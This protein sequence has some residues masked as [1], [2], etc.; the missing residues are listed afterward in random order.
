MSKDMG[1]TAEGLKA[2]RDRFDQT[3]PEDAD[4]RKLLVCAP[5]RSEIAGNHTDHEGGQV[6]ACAVD[7][8]VTGIF[9]TREDD[10]AHVQSAGYDPVTLDLS[11]LDPQPEEEN[12]TAALVRGLV[13]GF[14][15]AGYGKAGSLGFDCV[16]QSQ[17]PA[18]S[19][20]SSSA[21]FELQ[22]AQALNALWA[23]G[24]LDAITLAQ[25][26]QAA[27][28]DF[29]GKPCG[30]MDQ[31]SVSVGGLAHMNFHEAEARVQKLDADFGQ[32]GYALVLTAVGADHAANTDDYAAVPSEMQAVA[33][34]LGASRLSDVTEE[35]LFDHVVELRQKLGDRPVLRALHY[36]REERFVGERAKALNE[37]D[38]RRFLVLTRASGASSAMYLQNVSVGGAQTQPAMVALALSEELLRGRG[39]SRIHGGGFG[40]TIQAFV[41][42]DQAEP[43][44][45]RMNAFL[46]A[47]AAHVYSVDHEGARAEWL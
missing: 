47:D 39:A 13:A 17:V 32:M 24:S 37:G 15:A 9:C 31:A 25:M 35:D 11:V 44:C 1:L 5:G 46:G 28:R 6:I 27:E 7:R 10:Q 8:Y 20:L 19:G 23:D 30:L 43:Y 41:P 16:I 22:I 40:G 29:F 26:S 38:I 12:T 3:F 42:L 45:Q 21:A 33:R 36:F 14:V 18:G 4:A 2:L 34:E